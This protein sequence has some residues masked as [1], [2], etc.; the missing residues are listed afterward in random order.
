MSEVIPPLP[1]KA[2]M[3][4]FSAKAQG[5]MYLYLTFINLVKEPSLESYMKDLSQ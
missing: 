2:F 1:Q 3:A 4:W 5:Q